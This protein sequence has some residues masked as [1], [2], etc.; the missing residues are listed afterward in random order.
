LLTLAGYF[1]VYV[2]TPLDLHYHLTT[3]LNRL[4]LQLWPGAIFLVFM[5]AAPGQASLPESAAETSKSL[6]SRSTPVKSTKR[7]RR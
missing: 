3:S 1:A 5:A 7:A 4:F 6:Q 2:L